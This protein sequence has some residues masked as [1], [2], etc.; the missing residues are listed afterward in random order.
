[1]KIFWKT[2]YWGGVRAI[3]LKGELFDTIED[4]KAKIQ[5]E[6]GI[7]PDHPRLFFAGKQLEDGCISSDYTQEE[8][9][10]HIM[11]RFHESYSTPKK[12]KQKIKK[13]KLAVLKYGRVD[14]KGKLHHLQ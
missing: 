1:M 6:E 9:T 2:F 13:G 11:L 14:E 8:P 5:C 10:L 3:T 4:G 7:L 12:N